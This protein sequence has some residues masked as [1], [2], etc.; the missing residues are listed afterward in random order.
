MSPT[1]LLA[2]DDIDDVELFNYAL[3]HVDTNITCYT[4]FNGTQALRKLDDP[5]VN[6]PDI[7]FLDINMPEMNGWKCLQ[8]LKEHETHKNIPV[9]M[10]STSSEK[11]D[12][13]RARKSGALCYYSKPGSF[14][15]LIRM[16]SVVKEHVDMN[17]YHNLCMA[18]HNV[19]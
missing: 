9:I 10:Y 17:S 3:S 7:I 16:L 12:I 6:K 11:E 13:E 19:S 5:A 2:D 4:A 1:F 18:I 14:P 8:A 15:E